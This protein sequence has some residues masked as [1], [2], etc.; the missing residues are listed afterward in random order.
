MNRADS[1]VPMLTSQMEAKWTRAE[2][3]PL[4][5]IQ[6]PRNVDSKKKASNAS[7]A[8]GAPKTL[9]T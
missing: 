5:K 2:T 8:S 4:P 3:R 1:I 6:I 7:T 9:P